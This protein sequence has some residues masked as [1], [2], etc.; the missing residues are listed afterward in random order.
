MRA[1]HQTGRY[2]YKAMEKTGENTAEYHK[3][4]T[5]ECHYVISPGNII[6]LDATF[7]D[8]IN[9]KEGDMISFVWNDTV[10]G[11]VISAREKPPY[12]HYSPVRGHHTSPRE[13]PEQATLFE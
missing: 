6:Q 12:V 9:A 3:L 5:V 13:R 7:L 8:S 11:Y 2:Q 10:G 4:K 1:F